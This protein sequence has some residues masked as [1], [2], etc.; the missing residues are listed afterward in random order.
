[1]VQLDDSLIDYLCQLCRIRLTPEE[2]Q[3]MLHE[4]QKILTHVDQL[5]EVNTDNV[6]PCDHVM[7]NMVNVSREDNTNNTLS[8]ETF[9]DNVPEHTGGMVRVPSILSKSNKETP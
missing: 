2:R 8:R 4:L 7:D 3:Q 1:M 5:Q 9:L 6:K